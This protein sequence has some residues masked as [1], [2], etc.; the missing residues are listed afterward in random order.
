[1]IEKNNTWVIA[2]MRMRDIKHFEIQNNT[3][4]YM[5]YAYDKPFKWCKRYNT[6]K[7]LPIPPEKRRVAIRNN[8][9]AD[10]KV[11]I[12]MENQVYEYKK[13]LF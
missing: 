2:L 8:L 1:M 7:W 5:W 4:L 13:E 3:K 10:C 12:K 6:L 9:D 11:Y